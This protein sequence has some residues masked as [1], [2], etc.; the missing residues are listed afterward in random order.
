MTEYNLIA[1]S[2]GGCFKA[3]T[4]IQQRDGKSTPIELLKEGDEVLSFDASGE[5]HAA[6]ITKVHY[7]ESPEPILLVKF[8]G[9]EINITPNHWVLNQY[10]AFA[11]MGRLTTHDALVDGMGHLR[12]IISATPIGHEPVWNLTVE[13]HHTF[14]ADGV[15]VHNGGYRERFPVIS[16]SGGGGSKGGGRAAVEDNDTLQSKAMISIV[17]LLGEG[18][19]GGLVDGAKS[20]YCD[21]TQIQNDDGTYNFKDVSW[22]ARVGEQS[23]T[24]MSG[25]SDVETV[26]NVGVKVKKNSPHVVTITNVNADAVTVV[27]GV[28]SLMS[29]DKDTGDVHGTELKFTISVSKNNGPYV[30]ANA[31]AAWADGGSS[32]TATGSLVVYGTSSSGGVSATIELSNVAAIVGNIVFQPEYYSN[33]SWIAFHGEASFSIAEGTTVSPN[34][35]ISTTASDTMRMRVVSSTLTQTTYVPPPSYDRTRNDN[36]WA[37]QYVIPTGGAELTALKIKSS[38]PTSTITLT[39][40]TRS[41]YQRSFRVPLDKTGNATNWKIKLTRITDDST[42][43]ALA[44]DLYFDSYSEV[45]DAKLSYPNSAIVGVRIDSSQFSQIPSRSYLVD[46]RYI[47][48]PSNYNATLRTYSGVWNGTFVP[49][50]SNN[51]AWILYDILISKRFG[52]GNYIA[53]AQIDKAKLYQIAKYCDEFVPD[54]FGGTEPRFVIN[55]AIQTQ[56][57]AYKLISDISSVFRGMAYWAGGMVGMTQDAPTDPSMVFTSANV[58][59]GEF[60]Y[61]GSARKD[62]HSVVLVTWN[63]PEQGYKQVIEYVE[64]QSLVERYGVRK[65][66]TV[67]FGC[68]SRGQAHRVGLWILYTEKYESD[69]IQFKVGLDAALV[70]PGEVIKI[71]DQW[72]AGKRLGGRIVSATSSS[73]VLDA[74]V[75]LASGV[76]NISIRL[77][78]GSFG[79]AT[80]TNS[81]GEASTVSWTGSFAEI[82]EP[83]AVF[84]ISEA[85]LVPMLARVVGVSQESPTEFTI[86]AL[87]HNPAKYG[88]IEYGLE[89]E[90]LPTS[91]IDPGNVSQVRNVSVVEATYAPS[92]LT[93]AYKLIVSW[94]G[95]AP[96]Y[97]FMYRLNSSSAVIN[98]DAVSAAGVPVPTLKASSN[99]TTITS[100]NPSI[101]ILNVQIGEV[102]EM[103]ITAINAFGVRAQPYTFSYKVTGAASPYP[104]GAVSGGEYFWNGRDC[105]VSWNFNSTSSSYEFGA[106]PNGAD[107][108]MLDPSF[109]DYEVT[110]KNVASNGGAGSV[111]RVEYVT[112]NTYT[113]TYDKN[114]EDTLSR[115]VIFEI[116][117]RNQLNETGHS[118]VVDCENP[119]PTITSLT[120]TASYNTIIVNYTQNGDPDFAGVVIF[121]DKDEALVNALD[122]SVIMYDGPDN[123]VP[124]GNVSYSSNYYYRAFAYD[125]FGKIGTIATPT[126]LIHTPYLDTDA[127]ADGVLDGTK[128]IQELRDVISLITSADDVIGSVN[129]RIANLNT[130]LNDVIDTNIANLESRVTSALDDVQTLLDSNLGTAILNEQTTRQ[131]ADQ[132]LAT[133]ITGVSSD[134]NGVKGVLTQEQTARST[135]DSAMAANIL[136]LGTRMGS[137]ESAISSEQVARST[138]DSAMAANITTLVSRVGATEA[139][140]TTEQS[141]RATADTAT[142]ASIATLQSKVN[143]N[144]SAITTEQTTRST[145]D[146]ALA[147]DITALKTRTTNAESAI[148]NE[149]STRATAD[150]ANATSISALTTRVGTTES[151][152]ASEQSARSSADSALTSS[153]NSLLSRVGSAESAI[154]SEQS[155]R[156]SADS[157]AATNLN[158][159]AARLNSGGETFNKISALNTSVNNVSVSLSGKAESSTVNQLSTTVNGHTST[160]EQNTASING[161]TAKYTVKTNVN[162]HIAG[163]GLLSEPNSAGVTTSA[164]IVSADKFAVVMPGYENYGSYPFTIGQVNGVTKTIISSAVIGDLAVNTLK[165]ADDSVTMHESRGIFAS[166]Y[167]SGLSSFSVWMEYPGQITI[168]DMAEVQGGSITN[169]FGCNFYLKHSGGWAQDAVEG[170]GGQIAVRGNMRIVTNVSSGWSTFEA[171]HVVTGNAA[172]ALSGSYHRILILKKFK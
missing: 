4:L 92:V 85:T 58:I 142:A 72:R 128:L 21:D 127:I 111:R 112:T 170:A 89:L 163:F 81:G 156:A 69:M 83:G 55:T 115:H 129:E 126:Q 26:F 6:R 105:K 120:A 2:G 99:W 90:D 134:L 149:Q 57:D 167:M 13:P 43:S 42:S 107:D 11:E 153:I 95:T 14:I 155:T 76:K 12:P 84:V 40:K 100:G 59:G 152:I 24:P 117:Q 71:H 141:T 68:T 135:A 103:Q 87:E 30:R 35:Y 48:V 98:S 124:I 104:P 54:G 39:G 122:P 97:E 25:F 1:G 32:S 161:V 9:G 29:Q 171:S 154:S 33:G 75:M 15:R 138:A 130:R 146:S 64:E 121:L 34:V 20:I 94:S 169:T 125:V 108:G 123:S 78:N 63:D 150:S 140:I 66:D 36:L 53:A 114:Y 158:N 22:D 3:G 160:I 56:A 136:T 166:G 109:K 23:Q 133:N 38:S 93:F 110:V 132:A 172:T 145:A 79:T 113:Y 16:G 157:A 119:P 144:T 73:A 143:T 51:P 101:D 10:G 118:G 159:L 44:N 7:H 47:R 50:V 28:P 77:P 82:P 65:M 168:I 137:A 49:A 60:S 148:L 147:S 91:I 80:L 74:P 37:D 151:A 106:E 17:D 62:R 131:T 116:R 70:M 5:V 86:S 88:A 19:I 52:L 41:H 45:V 61:T 165:I 164:F 96:Q 31:G 18:A 27:A 67:A 102:Y 8:W 139:A 46:G 162:G